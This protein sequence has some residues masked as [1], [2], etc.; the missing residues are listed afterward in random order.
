MEKNQGAK[1]HYFY[2]VGLS[3]KKA[4]A[5]IRGKFSLDALAKT[6]L[7]QQ[8]KNEGIPALIVTSTCNR[9]EIYGYAEHPFQLIKLLCENSQGT[10]EEFQKVAYVFKNQ[11]AINHIFRVG[12]GLDSQILGDFEI[13]S[14]LKNG[15]VESKAMELTNAFMERLINSVIQA[16]KKIKTDT[17][18]SSGATSVSFASVQY[19]MKNVPDIG[20]KNILLFGTGKIGRNTCENLVKHTKNEHI[21]LINRTKDKAEKLAGK[22]NLIVKDHSELHLELQKADVVVVATGAQKPTVDKAILNLKKPM[23]ILDLSIPKNVHENVTEI[24][25]VTLIHLDHLSQMTDETLENRKLHIPAAEEIIETIKNEFLVW[26]KSRK[27]APTIHALKE[28]LNAI[29]TAELNFQ[30]KKLADF[31]EEQAEIISNRIIQKITTHFANHLKDEDTM[32]DESIE[33]IEKIFQI[34]TN[35]K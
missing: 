18:I 27:F 2:S 3:Y 7:L 13:I 11:D 1:H 33:W 23:L 19:I 14:Q 31:N 26:T 6:N 30:S 10:V 21:T 34:E 15:F 5:A 8:A 17:E 24:E 20:N 9:T 4:D 29:K 22:L 28:K 25:G 12:T 35:A 32:V 16:S